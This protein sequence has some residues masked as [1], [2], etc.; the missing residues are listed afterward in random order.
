[1]KRRKFI[2]Y[3]AIGSASS[4]A[5]FNI[6]NHPNQELISSEKMNN[7]Q[8]Y[9]WVILYWM[10][11][12]NDL[13]PFGFPILQMLARG[14][15]SDNILVVVQADFLGA[16]NL[17]RSIITKG[18]VE[19]QQLKTA[20]SASEEVFAE[21]LNWANSQFVANKWAIAFL[22]HGG[23]LDKISPDV[24][25]GTLQLETQWMNIKKL[26]DVITNFNREIN[27]RVELFFFQNCNKGTIEAHYTFRDA[28][29]YTLS[30]QKLLGAPNYYYESTLQFLGRNLELNGGQLAEKIMKFE[31]SDMYNSYTV[32]NNQYVRELPG[33]LNPLI[34]K[35]TSSKL[36]PI[37][38]GELKPYRYM[39]EDFIDVVLLIQAIAKEATDIQNNCDDFVDFL[40]NLMIYKYHKNPA[41]ANSGL[42]GLGLL[43][44]SNKEHLQKYR[45]LPVFS[46][47]K[48]VELFNTI[49]FKN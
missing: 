5:T 36:K 34:D 48:L 6:K 22:G 42:S 2:Q 1:M 29:N 19:V 30:S 21:Y 37:N 49:L 46:E 32:T 47:L 9:K 31:R 8:H 33:K 14:V 28:A 25:T 20:N 17:S 11:Y 15:Q 39:D 10:P 26:S 45:Y 35:I 38:W 43:L 41:K 27:S 7:K 13:Y 12:D 24:N 16:N 40:K 3:G 18:K 4:L 23:Q 44:P